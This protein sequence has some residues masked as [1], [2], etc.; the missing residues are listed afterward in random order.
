MVTEIELFN[1]DCMEGMKR[2]P[3]KYFELAIV[4]PPFRE[5]NQPTQTMRNFNTSMKQWNKPPD[6][7]Y[8]GELFRVSQNQIIHGGN[9]FTNVLD[10]NNNWIV[11]YKNNDGVGFS[12][13][14]LFWSSI[15]RNIKLFDFRPMGNNGDKIHPTQKPVKLYEWLLKNY[16]KQGDKIL[17]T[18]LGSGSI[19]IAC[20]NLDFSLTGFEID[21][22]YY[23]AACKRF[24]EHKKQQGLFNKPLPVQMAEK[25]TIAGMFGVNSRYRDGMD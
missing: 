22:D 7:Q 11:W 20:F 24:E 1:E 17:D 6:R 25:G 10:P 15:E 13:C 9:Y 3:D 2:Y 8:F 23:E 16:A 19:A 4:D 12:M 21:K 5:D 14:E 18:H